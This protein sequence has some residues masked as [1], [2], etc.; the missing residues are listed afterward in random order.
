MNLDLIY[1]KY[2]DGHSISTSF[3]DLETSTVTFN[4]ELR[5]FSRSPIK[6]FR[7]TVTMEGIQARRNEL[8]RLK[9]L[10]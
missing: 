5:A 1:S 3:T 9:K 6:P 8:N 10:Y 4:E 7:C 2:F